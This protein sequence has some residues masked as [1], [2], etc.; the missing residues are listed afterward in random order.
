MLV[1]TKPTFN[2]CA[3]HENP[4]GPYT[5]NKRFCHKR[6]KKNLTQFNVFNIQLTQPYRLLIIT[7]RINSISLW[8]Q[9]Y[10]NKLQ[11]TPNLEAVAYFLKEPKVVLLPKKYDQ[12]NSAEYF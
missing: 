3:L 11:S 6:N 4:F 5:M 12:R 10:Y 7:D 8:C 1:L 9:N 2:G